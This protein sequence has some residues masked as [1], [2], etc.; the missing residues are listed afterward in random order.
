MNN[1]NL[2]N[3]IVNILYGIFIYMNL[4]LLYICSNLIFKL[5]KCIYNNFMNNNE[6]KEKEN[7]ENNPNK[8]NVNYGQN[9]NWINELKMNKNMIS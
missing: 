3:V 8:Y 9:L 7:K 4:Y 6:N 2:E 5:G 1:I